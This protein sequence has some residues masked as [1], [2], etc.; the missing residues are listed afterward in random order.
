MKVF[1][2]GAT[3]GVGS[4]AVKELLAQGFDVACLVRDPAK[5]SATKAK[6]IVGDLTDVLAIEKSFAE[7]RP[8]T[9][10]HLGWIGIDQKDKGSNNQILNLQ[11][12]VE[13]LQLATKYGVKNFIGMGSESEYG[14]HG[15]KIDETAKTSPLT[16]YAIAKLAAG[17]LCEKICGDNGI[18]FT[19]LRLFSSYGPGDR[20]GSLMSLLIKTLLNKEPMKLSQCVQVWDYVHAADIGRL[21]TLIASQPKEQGIYNLGGGQAQVLKNIVLKIAAEINP[22]A[23]LRF[24]EIPYGANQNMHLEADISK[25]ARVYGWTP[26]VSLEQGLHETIEWHKSLLGL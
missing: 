18:H 10:I 3:G 1:V 25:L 15:K 14:V 7:F 22:D 13:L 20:Q 12:A 5:I 16:K 21:L 6:A 26:K 11:A 17:L 19:W 9:I 23:D 24:G 4:Y 2:T 8:D